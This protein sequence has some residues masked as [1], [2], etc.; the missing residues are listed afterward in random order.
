MLKHSEVLWN[1]T[2]LYHGHNEEVKFP[3]TANL[4]A[5]YKRVFFTLALKR[6]I[7]AH[8]TSLKPGVRSTT[9]KLEPS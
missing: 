9:K 1:T 5:K 3:Q 6:V 2:V 8:G 7:K 4:M